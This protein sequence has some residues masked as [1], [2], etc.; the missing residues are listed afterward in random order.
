MVE[1]AAPLV[2]IHVRSGSYEHRCPAMRPVERDGEAGRPGGQHRLE[3]TAAW[4]AGLRPLTLPTTVPG[5]GRPWCAIVEP[6]LLLWTG[7]CGAGGADII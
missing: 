1:S 3:M 5:R 2:Y 6:Q 4:S 7:S